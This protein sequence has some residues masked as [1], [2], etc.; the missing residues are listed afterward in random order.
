[1]NGGTNFCR[2]YGSHIDFDM[3]RVASL[4]PTHKA[5]V[6]AVKDVTEK[7]SRPAIF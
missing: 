2:L 3:A 4:Y 7:I 6:S 5:Y 1:V